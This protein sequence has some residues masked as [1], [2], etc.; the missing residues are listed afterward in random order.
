MKAFLNWRYYVIH[1]LVII[2]ILG[3]I[4]ACGEPSPLMG[5]AEYLFQTTGYLALTAASFYA[6][7]HCV[8]HWESKGEIPEI[9]DIKTC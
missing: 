9:S 7:H 1:L 4:G 2:G 5:L 8:K 6:L 3:I